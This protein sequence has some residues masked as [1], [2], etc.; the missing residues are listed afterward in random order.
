MS[1]KQRVK[2]LRG[3]LGPTSGT[4]SPIQVSKNGTIQISKVNRTITKK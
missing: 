3:I 1:K 4:T 2:Q